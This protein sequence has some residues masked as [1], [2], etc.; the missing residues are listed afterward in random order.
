MVK[1]YGFSAQYDESHLRNPTQQ[2]HWRMVQDHCRGGNI[3]ARTLAHLVQY[4]PREDHDRQT[5]RPCRNH[6]SGRTMANEQ[7][8]RRPCRRWRGNWK[9]RRTDQCRKTKIMTNSLKGI[10]TDIRVK[11]SSWRRSTNS[12]T[13]LSWV[14]FRRHSKPEMQCIFIL[15]S[16]LSCWESKKVVI[17]RILHN[18]IKMLKTNKTTIHLKQ[19]NRALEYKHLLKQKIKEERKWKNASTTEPW[20]ETLQTTSRI[21]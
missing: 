7:I 6:S 1:V 17:F 16:Y 11:M 14:N 9:T 18:V 2:Q 8:H 13:L 15:S 5:G 10:S 4:L 19:A 21:I 20:H 12:N 3:Y